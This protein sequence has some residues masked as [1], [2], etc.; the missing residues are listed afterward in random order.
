MSMILFLFYD[1]KNLHG[2]R[3]R[4]KLVDSFGGILSS[5]MRQICSNAIEMS[6]KKKKVRMLRERKRR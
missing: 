2:Q 5:L 3:E 1:E 6:K 4:G